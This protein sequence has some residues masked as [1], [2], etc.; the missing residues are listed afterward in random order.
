MGW[1][2]HLAPGRLAASLP[3]GKLAD[4]VML[5]ARSPV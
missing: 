5:P 4:G 3:G 1:T 2:P